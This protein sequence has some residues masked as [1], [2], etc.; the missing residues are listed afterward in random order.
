MTQNPD[1]MGFL[2]VFGT[3]YALLVVAYFLWV[4][5]ELHRDD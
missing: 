2:V 1:N 3:A 4:Y 5:I